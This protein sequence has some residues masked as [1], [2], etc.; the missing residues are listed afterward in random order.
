MT[1]ARFNY[2][3]RDVI[4]HSDISL[5]DGRLVLWA[6]WIAGRPAP[7]QITG[8]DLFQDAIALAHQCRFRVYLLGGRPGVVQ[9]LLQR[10]RRAF[11]GLAVD[12]TDG[13]AFSEMATTPRTKTSQTNRFLR[14]R[15]IFVALGARNKISGLPT[16]L[17]ASM[18]VAVGVGGVSTRRPDIFCGLLVD[19]GR[20][21]VG[22]QLLVAPK[23]YATAS[24]L[25]IHQHLDAYWRRQF[26]RDFRKRVAADCV[27]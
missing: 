14:S 18:A 4:N 8:H 3:F 25:R 26:G 15:L 2:R 23:R 9:E 16:T 22:F 20:F 27:R 21:R 1:L 12:G 17:L 13:G 24:C 6:T 19:A 10:L 5:A 11:P 7:E